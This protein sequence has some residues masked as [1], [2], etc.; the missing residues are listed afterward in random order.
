MVKPSISD[1]QYDC[2]G[3]VRG[4]QPGC[5]RLQRQTSGP[6]AMKSARSRQ[7]TGLGILSSVLDLKTLMKNHIG[8]AMSHASLLCVSVPFLAYQ[9]ISSEMSD[10]TDEHTFQRHLPALLLSEVL[11]QC[12]LLNNR[13]ANRLSR[14]F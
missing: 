14:R 11:A 9:T 12:L 6:A 5:L 4:S 2:V 3:V 8:I 1:R 7:L 10:P 13:F